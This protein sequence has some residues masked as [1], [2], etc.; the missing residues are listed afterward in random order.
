MILLQVR[1]GNS[2]DTWALFYGTPIRRQHCANYMLS[3]ERLL[4]SGAAC[5]PDGMIQ[6]AL[7]GNAQGRL[8]RVMRELRDSAPPSEQAA[9]QGLGG[10]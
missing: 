7:H 8:Y 4:R 9:D 10:A 2:A 6:D 1:L 3:F 5:D